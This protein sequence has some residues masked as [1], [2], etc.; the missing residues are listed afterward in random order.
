MVAK[1][2][3]NFGTPNSKRQKREQTMVIY[4][5]MKSEMKHLVTNITYAGATVLTL[6]INTVAQGTSSAE[7]VGSKIKIWRIDYIIENQSSSNSVRVT[8]Q[9]PN[10]VGAASALQY[11]G[12]VARD[13]VTLLKDTYYHSGTSQSPRG[14]MQTHKLPLGVVSK[15]AG[16]AGT[17][18]NSNQIQARITTSGAETL[19][20]HFR[21]WF[22]DV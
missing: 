14:I 6:G 1:R 11:S 16:A 8:L 22:T 21:I 3:L 20:G 2:A 7:R 13:D 19:V 12:A 10:I 17:T 9:I 18:I 5:G 15:Y 4:R